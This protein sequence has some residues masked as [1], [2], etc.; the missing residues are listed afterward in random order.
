MAINLQPGN[1][2]VELADKKE[3]RPYMLVVAVILLGIMTTMY[4]TSNKTNRSD[5]I[6]QVQEWKDRTKDLE[7]ENKLL[8]AELIKSITD[9]KNEQA[10]INKNTDSIIREAYKKGKR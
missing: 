2:Q 1:E 9:C 7:S 6:T 3:G 10:Q 8:R 5:V 4:F